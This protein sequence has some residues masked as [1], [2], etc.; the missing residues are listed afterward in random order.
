LGHRPSL[1]LIATVLSKYKSLQYEI[2]FGRRLQGDLSMAFQ[3]AGKMGGTFH[4][5]V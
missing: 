5:G 2:P 4:Q 1:A 3:T